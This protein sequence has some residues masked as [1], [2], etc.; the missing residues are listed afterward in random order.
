MCTKDKNT[1]IQKD[2]M[3]TNYKKDTDVH[4]WMGI[5]GAHQG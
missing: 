3:C 5:N 1:Y 4:K 2:M